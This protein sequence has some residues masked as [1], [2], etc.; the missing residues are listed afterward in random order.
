M[1]YLSLAIIEA[2]ECI[3]LAK[4][5]CPQIGRLGFDPQLGHT[6][7]SENG[8]SASKAGLGYVPVTNYYHVHCPGVLN[9]HQAA[10]QKHRLLPFEPQGWA[11]LTY[12]HQHWSHW[13]T[14][15]QQPCICDNAG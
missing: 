11:R 15:V 13:N 9:V 4:S 5:V 7:D 6:K 14:L 12:F 8:T 10:S 3:G 2:L 1:N